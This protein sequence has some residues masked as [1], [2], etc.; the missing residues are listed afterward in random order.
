VKY[1]YA[2][3]SSNDQDL[4]IQRQMLKSAGCEVIREAT[5]SG[6]KPP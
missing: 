5:V 6:V 3:V 2:R 1:G 4:S